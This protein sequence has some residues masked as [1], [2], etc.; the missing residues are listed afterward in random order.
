MPRGEGDQRDGLWDRLIP[1]DAWAVAVREEMA[2]APEI[3][4]WRWAGIFELAFTASAST[5]S[6]KWKKTAAALLEEI[7]I[8]RFSEA[9]QRWFPQADRLRLGEAAGEMTF[10]IPQNDT[11][12]KGLCWI[13]GLIDDPEMARL[14]GRL[15]LSAYKK[16]PGIGPRA[17]S[18]GNAAVYALS[19]MPNEA[20]VGQLAMLKIKVKAGNAQKGIEKAL[21]TTAERLGVPR[22]E[23]EEMGVPGYGL[24]GVG[25]LEETFGDVT[26]RLEVDSRGKGEIL[27]IKGSGKPQK[28]VPA[29]VKSDFPEELKDLKGAAKDIE[30]MVPA[31]RDRIDNLFLQRKAWPFSIWKERYLDHPVVGLIARR[32][33]WRFAFGKESRDGIW[34][35]GR[36]VNVDDEPLPGLDGADVGPDVTV[37]LWHPVGRPLDDVLA[38]RN[39][40]E[41]HEVRQPFKQAHR[42]VYLLTDAERRTN[43]YSNRFAAH[44]LRQHQ[45]HALCGVRNWKNKLR[46]MV[47]DI[48]APPTKDLPQ[49][50]LRAEFWVEGI[51]DQYG[52]DT[53]DSGSFLY[54]ST[55]QV[56]FYRIN[57]DRRYAHAF[58]G[59][60][61]IHGEEHPANE[62][63]PLDL[64]PPL[65]F[66]EIL[67]DVDLFVG[68]CSVGNDPTW[69]D[70]GPEGTYANYWTNF[71]FG[72]LTAS[73]TTRKE[74]L[75]RLIPRLKIAS[76]CSFDEKFLKVRGDLRTYKIHLGSGNIL[77]E[78]NDQYLCIVPDGRMEKTAGNDGMFLP[79]EGD[80]TLSIILSKAL[81]L[82][83]DTKI[84][85]TTITRQIQLA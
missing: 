7:S 62:P 45:F 20:A 49:W 75:Q 68:V 74:V 72:D 25:R 53:T 29:Q 4:R 77:M 56:R 39:W 59:G 63:L 14:L 2:A 16:L 6:A 36:I 26:A 31:Q 84:T 13:A 34:H 11:A 42:E 18:V 54:L 58:G 80:R 67:R 40:L 35:D 69:A 52:R 38:W 65:V 60:Y 37:E 76:R 10:P 23:I 24:T 55:D 43:T 50:G 64:I 33:V 46:L 73:A 41:R 9:V 71:S 82:A 66:S 61:E 70:G 57:A 51:G 79:F 78:P 12:L 1:A 48:Y 5:P 81:L 21:G 85:D 32:L 22:E 17:V 3:D 44:V 28:S 19:Q 15:A 30:K 27:W 47:D 83:A 8:S